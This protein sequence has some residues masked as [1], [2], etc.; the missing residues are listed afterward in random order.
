LAH[1]GTQI[2]Q[3]DPRGWQR[4]L[5][6]ESTADR[7]AARAL[8]E[9]VRAAKEAL[10]GHPQTDLPLPEPFP[11]VLVTR[12][13]LEGL[14][15]PNLLRSVELLASTVQSAGVP[16]LAGVYLVGGSSRIPLV[17]QLIGEQLRL[18]PTNLDQPETAVALGAHHVAREGLSLRTENLPPA[19]AAEERTAAI[20]SPPRPSAQRFAPPPAPPPQHAPAVSAP[21]PYRQPPFAASGPAPKPRRKT[22]RVLLGS[23]LVLLVLG[24]IGSQVLDLM[25]AT[26][27]VAQ[28]K[29]LPDCDDIISAVEVEA[30]LGSTVEKDDIGACSWQ[31]ADP[32]TRGTAEFGTVSWQDASSDKDV[33]TIEGNDAYSWPRGGS[34]EAQVA[35]ESDRA[36]KVRVQPNEGQDACDMAVDLL[37]VAF[38][39]LPDA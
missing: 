34:C 32:D 18:L 5:R 12:A 14:V 17:A 22:G 15:R 28:A 6:P 2:S 29:S 13:E 9:D 16:S 25:E 30:Q 4:L 19:V 21:S 36:L 33:F 10:S 11:D 26:A 7:R 3:H 23:A 38:E 31:T 37:N 20:A 35:I 1:L 24:V 27:E 8:R 39:N